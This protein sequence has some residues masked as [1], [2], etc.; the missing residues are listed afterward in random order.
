MYKQNYYKDIGLHHLRASCWE[1]WAILYALNRRGELER[2]IRWAA[3]KRLTGPLKCYQHRLD[4]EDRRIWRYTVQSPR[5]VAW[6]HRVHR[7][8]KLINPAPRYLARGSAAGYAYV[9]YE[10]R[11]IVL[12]MQTEP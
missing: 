4:D 7:L 1:F 6:A 10:K 5:L 3:R 12:R 11:P 9:R 8:N 2:L